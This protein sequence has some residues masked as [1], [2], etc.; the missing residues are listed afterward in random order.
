LSGVQ[1]RYVTLAEAQLIRRELE[2]EI[3]RKYTLELVAA[4]EAKSVYYFKNLRN[5]A[6]RRSPLHNAYTNIVPNPVRHGTKHLMYHHMIDVYK[7]VIRP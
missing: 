6:R 7:E 4:F 3:D 2:V 1:Y 5:I